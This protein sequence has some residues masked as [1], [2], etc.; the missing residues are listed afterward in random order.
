MNRRRK[1]D[2]K[3]VVEGLQSEMWK[4]QLIVF[5]RFSLVGSIVFRGTHLRWGSWGAYTLTRK[6][7]A[8]NCLHIMRHLHR[9]MGCGSARVSLE[10]KSIRNYD[11][12][13]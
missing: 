13:K 6:L 3:I 11:M 8:N 9:T 10:K 7:I 12:G 2:G 4:W 1:I 5:F